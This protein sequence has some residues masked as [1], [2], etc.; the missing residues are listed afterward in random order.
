MK[1]VLIFL[2]YGTRLIAGVVGFGSIIFSLPL[3]L[4]GAASPQGEPSVPAWEIISF[5][6]GGGILVGAGFIMFSS[7]WPTK[8]K[9]FRFR[10]LTFIFLLFPLVFGVILT[11]ASET[12]FPPKQIAIIFVAFTLWLLLLCVKPNLLS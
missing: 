12:Q 5:V 3:S 8:F 11:N 4:F 2:K 9:I 1:T 10:C 7:G 6:I